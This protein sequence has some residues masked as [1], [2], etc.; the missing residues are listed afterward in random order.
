MTLIFIIHDY[1][2]IYVDG[3]KPSN[4]LNHTIDTSHGMTEIVS[5]SWD[6]TT[7]IWDF[8][9]GTLLKS[10]E[11]HT[12]GVMSVVLTLEGKKIVSGSDDNT[13]KIGT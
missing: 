7:K 10:L 1:S 8:A 2:F 13:I 6:N 9:S 5:G 12:S 4:V 11:G 3:F